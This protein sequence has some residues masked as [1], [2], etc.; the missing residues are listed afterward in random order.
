MSRKAYSE[1]LKRNNKRRLKKKSKF[2]T[3]QVRV[4]W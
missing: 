3:K 1:Q 4:K 2:H